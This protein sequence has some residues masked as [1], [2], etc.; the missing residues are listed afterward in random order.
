MAQDGPQGP[1]KFPRDVYLRLSDYEHL[2]KLAGSTGSSTP[3]ELIDLALSALEWVI[4]KS[5][6]EGKRIIA[7]SDVEE[8]MDADELLVDL[9][10]MSG[11]KQRADL[12]EDSHD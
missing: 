11:A 7:T 4:A 3:A 8:G 9:G 1:K 6:K 10:D 12:Q 2:K 5:Q